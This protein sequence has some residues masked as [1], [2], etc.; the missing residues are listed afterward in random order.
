MNVFE[1]AFAVANIV[2][3]AGWLGLA[4]LPGR[5]IVVDGIAGLAIPLLLAVAYSALV[6]AFLVGAEG[7]FGTLAAV[8]QLFASDAVL[9]A[10]WL[11]YLAFDLFVGAWIVR[12]ARRDGVPHILVLPCL[13]FTFLLGPVGFLAFNIVRL[14]RRPRLLEEI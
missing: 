4:V 6:A 2:A 8:R 11:H 1:T 10:G 9:L 3:V 13:A 7:G 5:R 14:A 12:T